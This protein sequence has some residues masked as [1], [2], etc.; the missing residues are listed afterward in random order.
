MLSEP[1]KGKT[2][3]VGRR[4][5]R[6]K[7]A[8]E[9]IC[10]RSLER[11]Q[12][13]SKA[14]QD[15]L[16]REDDARAA[17]ELATGNVVYTTGFLAHDTLQAGASLDGHLGEFD[18]LV[19]IKCRQWAA[20][21]DCVQDGKIPKA[22]LDQMRHELWLTGATA[23]HYVSWNPDFPPELQLRVKT[24]K[25]SDLELSAYSLAAKLFLN[26]VEAQVVAMNALR[27]EAVPA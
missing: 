26:E 19:S 24:L 2:E 12:F 14:M 8:L 17:Y 18:E 4:D 6:L 23:H 10:G 7:L 27:G 15:G 5:L 3:T 1:P 11:D 20:H 16:D 22:A 25:A 9:R 21:W 13:T